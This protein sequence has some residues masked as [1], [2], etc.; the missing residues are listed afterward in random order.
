[1]YYSGAFSFYFYSL[2]QKA[3]AKVFYDLLKYPGRFIDHTFD[4]EK[5]KSNVLSLILKTKRALNDSKIIRYTNTALN[6]E[7]FENLLKISIELAL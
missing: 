5:C 3:R 6:E 7:S 1:M 4:D 2:V